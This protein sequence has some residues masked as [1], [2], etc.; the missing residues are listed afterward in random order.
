MEPVPQKI[1]KAHLR[2]PTEE[3][4]DLIL[5]FSEAARDAVEKF[6]RRS[7][8]T[9]TWELA[10]DEGPPGD[11]VNLPR[12]PLV[13][14]ASV[15]TF[16]LTDTESTYS[17]VNYEVDAAA[18]RIFLKDNQIWPTPLRDE[19]SFVVTYTSGYGNLPS[20]V[21]PQIRLGVLKLT[22]HYFENREVLEEMPS[23]VKRILAPFIWRRRTV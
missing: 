15:K 23:E 5:F 2:V 14:V 10:I 3:E 16:D 6:L 9:Q 20:A 19:R 12:P 22:G 4:D 21:P 18:S 11:V 8:I 13:S 7:L 17:A 1:V